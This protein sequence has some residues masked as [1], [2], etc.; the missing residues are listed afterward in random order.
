ME[1]MGGIYQ[2]ILK[3]PGHTT[4]I[5][6]QYAQGSKQPVLLV[7]VEAVEKC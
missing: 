4:E 6:K 3:Y 7:V 5:V 1:K 2:F